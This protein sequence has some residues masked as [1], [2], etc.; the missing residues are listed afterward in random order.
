MRMVAGWRKGIE[1]RY[2][3]RRTWFQHHLCSILHRTGW[4]RSLERID[5]GRV[6]RLIFICKGNI[7]RSPYAEARARG[8]GLTVASFGLEATPGQPPDATACRLA[9]R[10]GVPLDSM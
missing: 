9:R 10:R 3:T 5:W 8:L 7:C 4:F 6:E 1:A 2:G